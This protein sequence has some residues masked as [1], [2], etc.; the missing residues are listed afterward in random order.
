MDCINGYTEK[1]NKSFAHDNHIHTTDVIQAE[2]SGKT[3]TIF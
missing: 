2:Q 1:H 3:N